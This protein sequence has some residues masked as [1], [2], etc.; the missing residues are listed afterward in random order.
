MVYFSKF[1]VKLLVK[2]KFEYFKIFIDK[3]YF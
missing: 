2:Y 1:I 3:M